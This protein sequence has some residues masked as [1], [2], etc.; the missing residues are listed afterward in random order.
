MRKHQ[1]TFSDIVR[2]RCDLAGIRDQKTL[3]KKTGICE[4]TIQRNLQTGRWSREHLHALHR[5]LHFEW[6]DMLVYLEGR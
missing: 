1:A 4:K 3:A 5:F 2:S 6:E